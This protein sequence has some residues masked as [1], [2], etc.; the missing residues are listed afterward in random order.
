MKIFILPIVAS[1]V[2][3]CSTTKPY[4][5]L[6]L[7]HWEWWGGDRLELETAIRTISE[8]KKSGKYWD[9]GSRDSAGYWSYEF[10]LLGSKYERFALAA[11][12]KGEKEKASFLF[13][14][15]SVYFG[16]AKYPL[17]EK[18]TLELSY[19]EKH[20][21]T[22]IKSWQLSPYPIELIK[23]KFEGQEVL[24][25][26]HLPSRSNRHPLIIGAN[27]LD[28][29]AA[30]SSPFVKD[31]IKRGF[32]V[33][34]F[35]IPGTAAHS[36]IKLTPQSSKI[37]SAFIDLLEKHPNVDTK[38][39]GAFG[40]SFAGNLATRLAY[41]EKRIRAVANICGPIH[42]VFQMSA[43]QLN[44]VD[45]MYIDG[46]TDRV[47]LNKY[48]PKE[49]VKILRGFSLVS[50]G[51]IVKDQ[52]TTNT[53]IVSLNAKNDYVAPVSDMELASNS[54]VDGIILFSGSDDHCPQ[55]RS[56]DLPIIADWFQ[57]KLLSK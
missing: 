42:Q 29:H 38:I 53:P 10:G 2:V 24:G 52:K 47:H 51:F 4:R 44:S 37:Y 15:A 57:E 26:L 12:E 32:G 16:L 50:Q 1:L 48:D 43:G 34:M 23:G 6:R 8:T 21:H 20:I 28:V 13:D 41:T 35:D 3:S 30:E 18:S 33:L 19:N 25:Y 39:V 5:D 46:F 56:K 31:L 54:S 49:L 14:R 40:M 22:Y 17:I 27:G 55:N 36:K 9:V 45:Q 11:E 7:G